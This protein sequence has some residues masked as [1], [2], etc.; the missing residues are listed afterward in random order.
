M[1]AEKTKQEEGTLAVKLTQRLPCFTASSPTN[2]HPNIPATLEQRRCQPIPTVTHIPGTGRGD[3]TL[4][5]VDLLSSFVFMS[6]VGTNSITNV[7]LRG[8]G[9]RKRLLIEMSKSCF[10]RWEAFLSL[11]QALH[12]R[13]RGRYNVNGLRWKMKVYIAKILQGVPIAGVTSTDG[14]YSVQDWMIPCCLYE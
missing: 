3:F 7:H 10:T 11:Y 1:T 5:A 9:Y 2:A 4:K 8:K 6:G 12:E 14:E 13:G